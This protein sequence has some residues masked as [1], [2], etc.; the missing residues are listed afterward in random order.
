MR[1]EMEK[2]GVDTRAACLFDSTLQEI[3]FN[4]LRWTSSVTISTELGGSEKDN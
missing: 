3:S 4:L 2:I 1:Q